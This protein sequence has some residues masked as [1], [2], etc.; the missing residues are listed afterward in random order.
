MH[1][2]QFAADAEIVLQRSRHSAYADTVC[3]LGTALSDV[4]SGM[5]FPLGV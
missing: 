2:K 4:A 1:L 5:Q 3:V